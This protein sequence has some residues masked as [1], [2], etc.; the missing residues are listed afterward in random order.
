[1]CYDNLPSETLPDLRIMA[2][3]RAQALLEQ[4]DRWMSE[5]DRDFSPE[6]P[7]TGRKRAGVGIYYFE[8]DYGDGGKT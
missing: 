2:R 8:G 6:V 7:G 5:R 4:L 1:V 3:D